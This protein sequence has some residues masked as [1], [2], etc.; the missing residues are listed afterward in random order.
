MKK[1]IKVTLFMTAL[2]VIGYFVYYVYESKQLIYVK[3][4]PV[5]RG[6]VTST[7]TAT[8]SG[9]VASRNDI[10]ISSQ[11]P[12]VINKIFVKEGDRVIK[13]GMIA[14]LE[15][16]E[17]IAQVELS[18][19]NLAAA[20]ASYEQ[21]IADYDMVSA[22]VNT[23]IN[24]AKANMENAEKELQRA[25]GLV[26]IIPEDDIDDI[27]RNHEVVAARYEASLANR[28]KIK[29]K[30]QEIALAKA[31]IDQMEA[32]LS[33]AKVNLNYTKIVAPFTGVISEI[34]RESGEY[35]SAG[36]SIVKL[37]DPHNLYIEATVD[38]YDFGKMELNQAVK[39]HIDAFPDKSFKGTLTKILPVVS[40]TQ[41][42]N[43][44]SKVE[45]ELNPGTD[46]LVPG[47]SADVEIIVG[48]ANDVPYVPTPAVMEKGNKRFV[49][50]A[51]NGK[52][53]KR[54]IMTGLS[55]WDLTEIKDG[56]DDGEM[57]ITTLDD[58]NLK[59]GSKVRILEK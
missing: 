16:Q 57:I 43:R 27:K 49:F 32:S 7:V 25:N 41:L 4:V 47:L 36:T 39:I 54:E 22:L 59:D 46:N 17:K 10:A 15:Q 29:V 51:E 42:E 21:T 5:K 28:T 58:I 20:K 2:L 12:G 26:N 1:Y 33:V 34:V 45:I 31:M 56:L 8:S 23:D 11:I 38:E 18:E 19:A 30:E 3:A 14:L 13:D 40:T 50:V 52:A 35:A 53:R 55:N 48:N 44:T 6:A 24:E 9:V 37:I